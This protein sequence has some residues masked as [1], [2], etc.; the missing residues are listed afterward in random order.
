MLIFVLQVLMTF[1]QNYGFISPITNNFIRLGADYNLFS[2][3][4]LPRNPTENISTV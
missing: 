1:L 3:T 2:Y 4:Y